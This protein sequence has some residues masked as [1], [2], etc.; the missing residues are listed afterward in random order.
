[1]LWGDSLHLLDN[2]VLDLQVLKHRLNHHI[3]PVKALGK[4]RCRMRGEEGGGGGGGGYI[5]ES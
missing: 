5:M 3:C 1:M 4:G 2:P